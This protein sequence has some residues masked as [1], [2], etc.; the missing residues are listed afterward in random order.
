MF[1][2]LK[3]Q[4]K[5]ALSNLILIWTAV[6]MQRLYNLYIHFTAPFVTAI[7]IVWTVYENMLSVKSVLLWHALSLWIAIEATCLLHQ[8]VLVGGEESETDSHSTEE[9]PVQ[10]TLDACPGWS[11]S[12]SN[13][14]MSSIMIEHSVQE[15]DDQSTA[16]AHWQNQ[17][18]NAWLRQH[19]QLCRQANHARH[20]Y[21]NCPSLRLALRG[22]HSHFN[23]EIKR[24]RISSFF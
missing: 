4:N 17:L 23:E 24:F 11:F 13:L 19:K 2:F 15:R 10:A 18:S 16:A 22:Q 21:L 14:R 7:N 20:S 8:L 9:Y 12:C 3:Y 6:V 1:W 5:R